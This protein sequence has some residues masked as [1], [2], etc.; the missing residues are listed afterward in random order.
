MGWSVV[1][2]LL[3]LLTFI[4]ESLSA[5]TWLA[6]LLLVQFFAMFSDVPGMRHTLTFYD[7]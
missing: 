3:L 7:P 1:L 5:S 6:V 4:A 2:F